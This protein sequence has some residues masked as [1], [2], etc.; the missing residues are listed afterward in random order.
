MDVNTYSK[1]VEEG[2]CLLLNGDLVNLVSSPTT[3][4]FSLADYLKVIF[5]Y[6]FWTGANFFTTKDPP[7]RR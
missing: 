1:G 3:F 4:Q 7:V 5:P 2:T 6:R